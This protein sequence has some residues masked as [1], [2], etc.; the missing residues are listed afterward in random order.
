M[1][2]KAC[3]GVIGPRSVGSLLV[4]G[5]GVGEGSANRD[6]LAIWGHILALREVILRCVTLLISL[7]L[8]HASRLLV[9]GDGLRKGARGGG[10]SS[11][12]RS[13]TFVIISKI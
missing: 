1:L 2:G 12:N 7:G 5:F 13:E 6:L 10:I 11:V 8:L 3:V 4:L 9:A